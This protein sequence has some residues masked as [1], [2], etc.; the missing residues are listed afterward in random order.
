MSF[1][2]YKGSYKFTAG[3]T[4][5]TCP[6]PSKAH[7]FEVDATK[8]D[9]PAMNAV[10]YEVDTYA[11]D[12]L[13]GTNLLTSDKIVAIAS[14]D[15]KEQAEYTDFSVDFKFKDGKNFDPA[16]KYKLAVV[17]SSS[18]D[19]DKFSGAPGSVLYVDDLEVTF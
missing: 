13:D 5:Y 2:F 16:K 10:L 8:T 15:G 12:I 1:I 7:I 9:L 3:K 19:G 4:Y 6:D 14:V 17:C 18:K 11:F